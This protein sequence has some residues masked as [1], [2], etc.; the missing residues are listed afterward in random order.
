MPNT[1]HR[2]TS[3]C[4]NPPTDLV[5][6]FESPIASHHN[7]PLLSLSE[8]ISFSKKVGEFYPGLGL[9]FLDDENT[10]NHHAYVTIGPLTGNILYLS[11]DGDTHVV[12]RALTEYLDAVRTAQLK[13]LMLYE[14]HPQS[15]ILARDQPSLTERI[16]TLIEEDD[17]AELLILI[18]SWDAL[19]HEELDKLV[20]HPNFFL[21]EAAGKAIAAASRSELLPY[22]KVL[23]Q[24][25]HPQAASAGRAAVAAI[26]K[27]EKRNP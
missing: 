8:A 3:I 13:D 21:A 16:R 2:L 17:E 6:Y 7:P 11:H 12:F 1:A 23:S 15:P 26:Q 18:A 10:S 20:R 9:V 14:L 25:N 24:H 4:S 22:A 27:K 19:S 5:S